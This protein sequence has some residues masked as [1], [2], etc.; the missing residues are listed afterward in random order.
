MASPRRA[1]RL[2]APGAGALAGV[3][4]VALVSLGASPPLSLSL[5]NL[6]PGSLPEL[7]CAPGQCAN[8]SIELRGGS[9]IDPSGLEVSVARSNGSIVIN[10]TPRDAL[11]LVY[12]ADSFPHWSAS[13][14]GGVYS[15]YF[16]ADI[17]DPGGRYVGGSCTAQGCV[18]GAGTIVSGAV[19]GLKGP[20][21]TPASLPYVLT[22]RAEGSAADALVE[23]R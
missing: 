12:S 23:L 18:A 21:S 17:V 8:L 19:L 14:G 2:G 10:G 6:G 16:E 4:L 9:P 3:A 11:Q 13:F 15:S 7:G 5:R 20:Y 22:L 1:A